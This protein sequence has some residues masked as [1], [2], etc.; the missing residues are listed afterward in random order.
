MPSASPAP[1]GRVLSAMVTPFDTD[2]GLDV[3]AAARIATHLVD[4]GHDGLVIS[5]TTGESPTLS[6]DEVGRLLRAVIDAVGDRAHIVAGVGSNDTTHSIELARQAEKAGA[7]GAL[8][9]TPYY[10]KP[11]QLGILHHFQAVVGAAG[12]PVMLYDVPGRTGVRID[13]DTYARAAE[14]D[15]IVAVK[16]AVGDLARGVRIMQRTGLKFYSGDDTLNLAWLTHGG[17]GIVSVVAHAAGD[18][19][20]AM[21]DHVEAG[22]VPEAADLY[23]QVL[24]LVQAIMTG[25]NYGAT[26][27]KA[28]LE[29]LG[30]TTNRVVRAPLEAADQADV[31]RLRDA[32]VATGL[33]DR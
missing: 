32:L 2:G 10:S 15:R 33:L 28:A 24:P 29:L 27:A 1:F 7:N 23:R 8:L 21:V 25:P 6:V 4:H 11:S 20:A 16:D 14:D 31:A 9:V 17:V 19:Y 3:D 18:L 12:L 26:M 5:G 13:E 30:V 22:R